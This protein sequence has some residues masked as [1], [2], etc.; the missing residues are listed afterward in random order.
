MTFSDWWRQDRALVAVICSNCCFCEVSGCFVVILRMLINIA[1]IH[2]E[3]KMN[4]AESILHKAKLHLRSHEEGR[5]DNFDTVA[6]ATPSQ[7]GC[8]P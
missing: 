4:A 2:R 5:T 1:E 8:D 6:A 7:C 3:T